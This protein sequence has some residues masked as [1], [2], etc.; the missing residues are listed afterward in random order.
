MKLSD[1]LIVAMK[2]QAEQHYPEES[3]GLLIGKADGGTLE[4]FSIQPIENA[5]TESRHNRIV[6]PPLEVAKAERAAAKR[7]LGVWGFYHTHPNAPAVP[8]EFDRMH[9]PFT[10]W[11]YPIIELR[12]G[13]AVDLRCWRLSEDRLTFSESPLVVE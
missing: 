13:K 12:D 2:R 9:F 7:G 5:K 3:G 11:W 8:S 6:L 1:E 4:V 10:Q